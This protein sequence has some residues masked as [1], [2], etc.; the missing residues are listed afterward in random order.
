ML[1]TRSLSTLASQSFVPFAMMLDLPLVLAVER[2]LA[3]NR[4][5]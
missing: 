1:E 2:G 4:R 5:V 3:R